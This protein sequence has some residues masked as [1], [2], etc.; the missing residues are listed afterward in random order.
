MKC[1]I[2]GRKIP[3]YHRGSTITAEIVDDDDNIVAVER[4][5]FS[6]G[7]KA[8]MLKIFWENGFYDT[9]L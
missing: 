9:K 4:Y 6:C 5:C 3:W 1:A 7:V 8:T 2:C